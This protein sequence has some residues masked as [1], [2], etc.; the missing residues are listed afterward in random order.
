MMNNT[1][2]QKIIKSLLALAAVVLLNQ[3]PALAQDSLVV[4]GVILSGINEPIPNVA[5]SI[6][7]SREMPAITGD[8]GR[9]EV[10]VPEGSTWMTISP[11]TRYKRK[12]VYIDKRSQID[13]VL[14]TQDLV[15]GDDILTVFSQPMPKKNIVS[16]YTDLDLKGINKAPFISIDQYMQ[17]RV[18]GL[19][20]VSQSGTPGAG[21]SAN[22]RGINSINA[23]NQPLFIID[24]MPMQQQGMFGSVI[25][26]YV[27]N[28]V[29][30]VN[31]LDISKLTVF[32]DPV[33]T[34]AYGSKASN[35]LVVIETLDPT[36]TETSFEVDLRRGYSMT[37]D[38]YMNQLD[39]SQHR[40]LVNE[41]LYS[42][43]LTEEVLMERYPSLFLTKKDDDFV[44]Y[45]HNTDWQDLIFG[46]G[47]FTNFNVKV[48]GG[49]EIAS[50]GLSLGFYDNQGIIKNTDYNGLN[51]RFVSRVNVFR[52]LKMN[53]SVSFNTSS[54][55]LKESAKVKET[56]PILAALGK[57]PMLSPYAYDNDS[58]RKLTK[59]LS[60]VEDLGGSNPL[61]IIQKLEASNKNYH[62][63]SN[64]GFE[65]TIRKDLIFNT[66]VGITYNALKEK[67]FMP[68]A[69]MESYYNKEAHNVIKASTNTLNS[70]YNHTYLRYNKV[71]NN[72]HQLVSTT[73]MNVQLNQFQY[74]WGIAKNANEN[75]QYKDLD[76]GSDPLREVGG[77]NRD[78]NWLSFYEN[79]S[80]SYRDKY[81]A[82][83]SLSL[84][85]SSRVGK[86]AANTL[87]LG[88]NPFGIFY[89]AGLGWRLSNEDFLNDAAWLE[90]FKLRLAIGRTG[91][92]DIG[93]SNANNFYR[94]IQFRETVGLVPVTISNDQLTYETVTQLNGGF[95]LALN[96]NRFRLNLDVY[97]SN[98]DNMLIYVPLE[99]YMGYDYRPEN[100][101]SMKNTGIDMNAFYRVVDQV[102]FKWD[103][104]ASASMVRNRIDEMEG[105][106]QVVSIL[107]GELVNMPGETANSF[108]GYQ[109]KGVYSSYD[110]ATAAGLKNAKGVAYKGGDAIYE[111][112]SGPNGTADGRID[113]YDKVALGSAMPT[114]H[115]GI[116]NT[117]RYGNWMFSAFVQAVTGN[118]VF[119]YVRYMNE[120]MTNI[121]NQS[122][123]V[124]NRW[125]YEGQVTDVPRAL[126]NDPV[127]N[128]AFS[129]RWIEDGTYLRLKN[130]VL[131]Y[132]I[133]NEFL[134]FKNAEFYVSATN[135]LTFSKY[136]GYDPE[137][138][139]SYNR[140]DQGIDYGQ[141]P[142]ARQFMLGIKF[143][144]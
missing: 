138:G 63:I 67:I 28:P 43:G 44:N 34:A 105:G 6:E 95:D 2:T 57:S 102:R 76:N 50:Y 81:M 111:D 33:Y 24:G 101:G 13:V 39:S 35:G 78:W 85:G 7:G 52:W 143:G 83:V 61:A 106:K 91:N 123:H 48:K 10:K 29:S 130:V 38:R 121:D 56:N 64:I 15:A 90:D 75:D 17:G 131:S 124:L 135:L 134:V 142:Q 139:Y 116:T 23:N 53:A 114:F 96:G 11:A 9:Y 87:K 77:Q 30:G 58:I 40:T 54:A 18:S 136:L 108:Y 113:E 115:G 88:G 70:F 4:R 69:G 74:D 133:P 117:F 1:L 41:I 22:M 104:Q 16:S 80:Y 132:T 112:I 37:P 49:D 71:F 45:R 25:E 72:D 84:D 92:D 120:R 99:S 51:L 97:Q 109:F 89:S 65:A 141:T 42:S 60:N 31:P 103:V 82:S 19:N 68:N 46:N 129:S 47:S 137:F 119:N 110:E 126:W 144:L 26:G 8:D 62:F 128:S 86:N 122:A 93:E 36:A 107:G 5:V 127:G 66:N 94:S 55:N 59:I 100:S 3:I 79:L 20:L 32:N 140:N 73:G 12:R 14:T 27:Y 21:M 98:V 125:Q 118:K